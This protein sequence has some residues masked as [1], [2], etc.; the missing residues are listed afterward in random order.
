V[1]ARD[2]TPIAARLAD[3]ARSLGGVAWALPRGA[4]RTAS[5]GVGGVVVGAASLRRAPRTAVRVLGLALARLALQV[6]ADALLLLAAR[7]V[8]AVQTLAGAEPPG[9]PL[10]AAE[11]ALL[12]RVYGRG[13]DPAAVRVKAGRLGL[14]GLPGRAFVVADTVYVP[15]R[16]ARG[17][18]AD[19]LPG[20]LV[21][22]LA[23]VWQHQ[24]HGTRYLSE[25][26]L[27]QWLGA[28]Y[29]VAYGVAAGGGFAT[30]V[31]ATC[32]F[33]DL[34][35]EQQAELLERAF[36]TG[37][38]DLAERLDAEGLPLPRL[39]LRLTEPRRDD[40]FEVAVVPDA[41]EAVARLGAGWLDATPVLLEGLASVRRPLGRHRHGGAG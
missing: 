39:L 12:R 1:A 31:F 32:V 8:S 3:A 34:N 2:A 19:G 22:E 27:A 18:L 11:L 15:R 10:D 20:L 5:R 9:R 25:C 6:P 17:S 24:R 36:D 21:H 37:W 41:A 23:H 13:I 16:S 7:L 28:G 4:L 29:N 35:F 33:A 40:G 26:L 14:L 38:L 30:R